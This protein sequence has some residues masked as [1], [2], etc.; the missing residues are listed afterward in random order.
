MVAAT[1]YTAARMKQIEDATVVGGHID[2]FGNL[3]LERHDGQYVLG[4]HVAGE[5]GAPGEKG[6]PGVVDQE[7]LDDINNKID[8]NT[9]AI[10]ELG[11]SPKAPTNLIL[12]E[13]TSGFLEDGRVHTKLYVMWDV[14]V[15]SMEDKP[16]QIAEYEIWART[17]NDAATPYRRTPEAAILI[18]GWEPGVTRYISARARAV[19]S[20]AWSNLSDELEVLPLFPAFVDIPPTKP[21]LHSDKGFVYPFWDGN[22]SE[23]NLPNGFLHLL[24]EYSIGSS[25]V[26][27]EDAI[28]ARR[29]GQTGN[30]RGTVGETVSVRF[31]W[32]DTIGRISQPS[33]VETVEVAGISRIDLTD[34]VSQAIDEAK[35]DSEAALQQVMSSVKSVTVEYAVSG[36]DTVAPT[37][38]WSEASPTRTPGTFIWTR[39]IITYLD[40]TSETSA[41]A[42]MTGNSGS[43]G[44]D[45]RGMQSTLTTYQVGNSPTTH[46]TGTWTSSPSATSPGQYLW[47]RTVITWT[48]SSTSTAYSV[49]AHGASG[50]PGTPGAPGAPG[51]PGAPGAPGATGK[52]VSSVTPYFLTVGSGN[53]APAKPTANPPGGSWSLTEPGYVS[54]TDL[55]RTEL[56]L[57][58]D[59]S[60]AYTNVTKVSAYTA[61]TQAVTVANLADAKSQGMVKAS[62]TDPGH[63]VGRIWVVLNGAGDM[64]G[65]K[66]SNGSAWTSYMMVADQI[67]VPSSVGTVSIKDGAITASKVILGDMTNYVPNDQLQNDGA[68]WSSNRIQ[69]VSFSGG[70]ITVTP[71]VVGGIYA[72]PDGEQTHS[73]ITAAWAY[74]GPVLVTWEARYVGT[75]P[76]AGNHGWYGSWWNA[77]G[78]RS[79]ISGLNAFGTLTDQWK[80]FSQIL[81]YPSADKFRFHPYFYN[82]NVGAQVQMRNPRVRRMQGGE[83]I[84]DGAVT[85]NKLNANEIWADEAWLNVLRAG[86]IETSMVTP[87]FG[88]TLNLVANG[89]INAIIETQEDL[90]MGIAE[91]QDAADAAASA[92]DL[93]DQKAGDAIS[94]AQNAQDKADSVA[95]TQAATDTKVNTLTTW[96][97][98]DAEGAHIGNSESAFE[99]H[100]KH[101]RFEITHN[102]KVTTHWESG[103]MVVP[104]AVVTN[105]ELSNHKMEPYG[106]GTIIRAIGV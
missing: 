16:I 90:S 71:T 81:N 93:V 26:W 85:A 73:D 83:L 77:A 45:G 88:D 7:I 19:G 14:V 102:K 47:T 37:T 39:T 18:E 59:N 8:D 1:S 29:A 32:S 69:D 24:T 105:I 75:A 95:A 23:G 89:A 66:I 63:Q 74:T 80:T 22:L 44:T 49:A 31:R 104:S 52:G 55:Y 94:N 46:P 17:E 35:A 12:L 43:S 84:V 54:S 42:V 40:D 13:N 97:R 101:D 68:G 76:T 91:A 38:G 6:D 103:R 33:A 61:A 86:V 57:Y 28:P 5:P 96:F 34:E 99:T 20:T 98:V 51:T 78:T 48:D 70:V 53:S 79:N 3:I 50:A 21:T 106:T 65:I 60:F 27:Q 10:E 82:L 72:R 4:G 9:N 92:V 62:T 100:V 64:I 58:T 36:S 67:L 2:S 25:G 11:V 56:I 87:D 15:S 41:P 30:I